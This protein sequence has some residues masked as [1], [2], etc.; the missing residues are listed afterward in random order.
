MRNIIA[1]ILIAFAT[2]KIYSNSFPPD[3]KPE[4]KPPVVK[5]EPVVDITI[6]DAI[7]NIKLDNVKKYVY[8]LSSK[9]F[10]GRGTGTEGNEKAFQYISSY[11]KSLNIPFKEQSFEARGRK[12]KNIIAYIVPKKV[13]NNKLIVIGAHFDHLGSSGNGYYPGADDNASGVAGVMAV[14]SALNSYK[15][16]LNHVILLQFYSAE[17]MGLLGSKYYTNYPMFPEQSPDINSHAVMIN[18]DMIGYLKRTYS[19][20]EITTRYREDNSYLEFPYSES[21]VDLRY[22]VNDLSSKYSFA[23]NIC[24]Y[25]PGGSDHAPFYNKGIPVVFL[26]TGLHSNYHKQSDTPDKLNYEGI[27]VVSKFAFEILIKVDSLDL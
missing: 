4:P 20:D 15:D 8:D 7:E 22:I 5:P 11:L 27:V 23:N 26:H 17:E 2:W 25:R 9:E 24:G 21:K 19:I 1:I 6:E 10:D 13:K 16:K 12:T 3:V 18:L 14:A